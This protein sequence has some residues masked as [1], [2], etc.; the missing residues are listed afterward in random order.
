MSTAIF[1]D[2][3]DSGDVDNHKPDHGYLSSMLAAIE[4][5]TQSGSSTADEAADATLPML[6]GAY[7]GCQLPKYNSCMQKQQQRKT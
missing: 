5:T 1:W 3:L 6:W 4:N 2:T 7:L